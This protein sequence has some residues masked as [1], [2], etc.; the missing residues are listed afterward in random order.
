VHSCHLSITATC[1]HYSYPSL[2]LFK[3]PFS[4]WTWVSQYQN[5]SILDFIGVKDDRGGDIWSCKTCKAPVK[6]SP[7][8]NQHPAVYRP[9]ALPTVSEYWREIVYCNTCCMH[10]YQLR[11]SFG[12][13]QTRHYNCNRMG[14]HKFRHWKPKF[15]KKMNLIFRSKN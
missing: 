11:I 8:T 9:D 7:P 3:Q 14:I 4:R 2:S 6:S 12:N 10:L 15:I 1:Q 13:Q 5:V